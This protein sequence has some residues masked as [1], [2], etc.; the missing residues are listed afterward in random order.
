MN[1]LSL[2]SSPFRKFWFELDSNGDLL[3][4]Y[5]KNA[6][7]DTISQPVGVIGLKGSQLEAE[8]MRVLWLLSPLS[9]FFDINKLNSF[10]LFLLSEY[11]K[12]YHSN[13]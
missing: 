7:Q 10:I 4:I 1:L 5:E 6:D 3:V 9:F 11:E 12:D 13:T 2:S 8:V